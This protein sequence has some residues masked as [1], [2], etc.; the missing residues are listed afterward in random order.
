MMMATRP[1][2]STG[3]RDEVLQLLRAT[4]DRMGIAEIAGRLGIHANTAR[5]HLDMLVSNGQV[6]CST[7]RPG[8][9]G[10]PAQRFRSVRGMDPMGARH[11]RML[12]EML[13]TSLAGQPDPGRAAAE[14]G[15]VWGRLQAT[16]APDVADGADVPDCRDR[17]T[18]VEPVRRLMGMLDELGFAP[19]RP[20]G[21]DGPQITL[22]NCPFLELAVD[23]S[24]IVCP[25]HLGLMQGALESW[26]SSLTVGRLDAFVEPDRC[27][28]HLN[29]RGMS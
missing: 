20:D 18:A 2:G 9:P 3:R 22:R 27:E 17:A 19:E 16:P 21:D 4:G 24:E 23:R 8:S 29:G 6:E 10:R 25:I 28:A 11:Y 7:D 5:F 13:V 1:A 15:R 12:A 26:G 14:A